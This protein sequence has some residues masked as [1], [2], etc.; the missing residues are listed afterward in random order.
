MYLTSFNP[1]KNKNALSRN[2]IW[3]SKDIFYLKSRK[4][5]V[6]YTESLANFLVQNNWTGNDHLESAKN[7]RDLLLR[8]LWQE[9]DIKQYQRRN[10]RNEIKKLCKQEIQTLRKKDIK[11]LNI[12]LEKMKKSINN[13]NPKKELI[14]N[15]SAEEM[16]F[17]LSDI[18]LGKKDTEIVLR[19]RDT[20]RSLTYENRYFNED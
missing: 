15:E 10:L 11:E 9:I 2:K 16:Y 4:F 3:I 20:G 13:H 6:S 12:Y 14:F 1:M 5:L 7:T 18:V 17:L 8:I 19:E